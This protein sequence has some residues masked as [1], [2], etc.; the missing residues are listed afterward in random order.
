[1]DASICTAP[2][3]DSDKRMQSAAMTQKSHPPNST[4]AQI[5][6]VDGL[7]DRGR[8]PFIPARRR[9]CRGLLVG[10]H[11]QM[12]REVLLLDGATFP[13]GCSVYN[14]GSL[15]GLQ[16]AESHSLVLCCHPTQVNR[17]FKPA[18]WDGGKLDDRCPASRAARSPDAVI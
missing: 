8:S 18:T 3:I 7:R 12:N 10:F 6:T 1:M 14:D 17:L 16:P 15:R 4:P 9:S 2:Q 5:F 13:A 11:A